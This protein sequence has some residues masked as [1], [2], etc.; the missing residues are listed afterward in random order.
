MR[1][2]TP[3]DFFLLRKANLSLLSVFILREVDFISVSRTV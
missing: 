3:P 1:M 2:A